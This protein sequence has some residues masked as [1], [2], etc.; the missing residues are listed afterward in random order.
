MKKKPR[1]ALFLHHPICSA[2]CVAGMHEAL[3]EKYDVR[4]YTVDQI[5]PN[6]LKNTKIIAFPGGEGESTKFH[7][8]LG[9]HIDF[10]KE[11][12]DKRGK[13]LGVCMGAYWA[14][15]K[16]FD[17]LRNL[18]TYQYIKRRKAEIKRSHPT[19]IDVYWDDSKYRMY[20]YDGC[21]IVGNGRHEAIASYMNGDAMAI[22]QNNIGIIGCH[23]ESM[24]S[25]YEK[26][27]LSPYWHR[28]L[29]HKL[30]AEFTGDLLDR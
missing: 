15:S 7:S 30:L 26:P 13:Y 16:Y 22:I 4:C 5:R 17:I 29:H 20:F 21:A 1:I 24:K 27:Y 11:F 3:Y 6:L 28:G 2:H 9:P 18:D 14:G 8:I 19:T 10:F 12:L 25:W 23:P